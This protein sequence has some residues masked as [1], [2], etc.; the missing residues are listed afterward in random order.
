MQL[1]MKTSTMKLFGLIALSCFAFFACTKQDDV[2]AFDKHSIAMLV[3]YYNVEICHDA[4]RANQPMIFSYHYSDT[5]TSQAMQ[6]IK[7]RFV[8]R[9]DTLFDFDSVKISGMNA[10]YFFR[11]PDDSSRFDEY[12]IKHRPSNRLIS[13]LFRKVENHQD[14]LLSSFWFAKLDSCHNAAF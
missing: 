2:V 6:S 12:V 7:E 4:E 11:A 10:I 13:V 5:D 9:K 14:S 8:V 1:Y 3:D